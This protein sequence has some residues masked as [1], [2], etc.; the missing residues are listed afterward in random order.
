[1]YE[2]FNSIEREILDNEREEEEERQDEI[3]MGVEIA[4][5]L[6]VVGAVLEDKLVPINNR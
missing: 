1:M 4:Q 2:E 5:A 3:N 6:Q